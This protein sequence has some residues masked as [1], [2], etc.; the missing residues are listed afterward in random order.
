MDSVKIN[1][2][3]SEKRKMEEMK[4]ESHTMCKQ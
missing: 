2:G 1:P 4:R 3:T